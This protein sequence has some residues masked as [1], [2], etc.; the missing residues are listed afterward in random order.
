MSAC[1]R[2]LR[3]RADPENISV[4]QELAESGETYPG[5]FLLGPRI[6]AIDS[7]CDF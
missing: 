6:I 7:P 4:A 2:D 3:S 1:A 5:V